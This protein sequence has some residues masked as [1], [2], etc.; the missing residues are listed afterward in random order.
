M[1][2]RTTPCGISLGVCRLRVTRVDPTTGCVLSEA[3]NG[4]VLE[5]IISVE[6]APNIETGTDT[7]LIGGCGCKIATY[8]APDILKRY[9]L[10]L[11]TP[12]KSAALESLLT[13]GGIL[14]DNSTTPVP[15]GYSFPT[16]LACDESQIPVAIEF[17]TKNWVDD[18]QDGDLPWIHWV[19]PY[20]IWSPGPADGQQRLRAARLRRLHA[21]ERLL[22]RRALRRRAGGDLR[23]VLVLAG[24]R[25]LVLHAD[26]SARSD[27]LLQDGRTRL[28][29]GWRQSK[30][31]RGGSPA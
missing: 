8:K 22:G 30:H 11:T 7:T 15:V 17:W 24:D 2:Q 18:A 13:D 27:L 16:D 12:I 19:F 3:D 20:S 21:L 14:Y 4:F 31:L 26:R 10:T 1:A 28:L 29:V 25:R 23:G 6:V 5:D 9:D